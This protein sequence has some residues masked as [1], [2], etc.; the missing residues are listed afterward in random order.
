[1]EPAKT[2]AALVIGN[3]ILSGKIEEK[4]LAELARASPRARYPARARRGRAGRDRRRSRARSRALAG[5]ARLALHVRRRRAR[6]TTTSRSKRVAKAFGVGV[7]HA[8]EMERDDPRA[9]RR[10][11]HGRSPAH[12]ARPRRAQSLE[13]TDDVRWHT[14]RMQK[15]LVPAGRA[16]GVPD[17]ARRRVKADIGAAPR[18]VSLAVYTKM[19]EGDLKPLLDRVVAAFPDVDVGLVPEMARPALQDEAHVRRPR[20]DPS[21]RRARRVRRDA[22]AGRA[23]GD[24]NDRARFGFGPPRAKARGRRRPHSVKQ[25]KVR[26]RRTR[27]APTR[28]MRREPAVGGLGW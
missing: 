6:R 16:R 26:L 28:E 8:P 3:E 17:E 19:D 21:A 20:R 9:L 5:V 12:G 7:V 4:N 11:L 1:M 10:A 27:I 25:A 15:R 24:L 14:V 23:A 18:F 22:P 2:A 13:V